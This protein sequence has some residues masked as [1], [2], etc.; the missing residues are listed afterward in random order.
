MPHSNLRILLVDDDPVLTELHSALLEN[1]DY[2]VLVAEDG[3]RAMRI[4]ENYHD[5]IGVVVSDINMPN[6]DGYELCA[7]LKNDDKTRDIPVIFVSGLTGLEEKL[8]GYAVG[9]DDYITKPVNEEEL[10]KKIGVLL[11]IKEK[12]NLLSRQT[13]ESQSMALQIMTFSSELGQVLEFYKHMLNAGNYEEVAGRC[14][15]LVKGFDLISIMQIHTPQQVLN[16]SENG[17]VSP[18]EANVIELARDKGR[19]FDFGARTIINYST[20]SLLIKNM[21]LHDP[22]KYGRIKDILSMLGNGLET[23]IY[24]LNN[25]DLARRRYSIVLS[26]QESIKNIEGLFS[27]LQKDNITAIEDMNEQVHAVSAQLG[28]T[29]EQENGIQHMTQTCLERSNKAFYKGVGIENDLKHIYQQFNYIIGEEIE[30]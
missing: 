29:E 28:L 24:Q 8:K 3:M 5:N 17:I 27:D 25:E 19:F 18:L 15:E 22:E 23:K 10:C 16:L 21:P 30:T 13:A 2:S 7:S 11:D 20:F 9:A 4:L 6:M 26:I 12:Q 14:F 1:N